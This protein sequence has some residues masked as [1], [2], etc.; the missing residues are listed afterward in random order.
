MQFSVLELDSPKWDSA[1]A[2]LPVHLRDI[3][4]LPQYAR[5]YANTYQ[6]TPFLAMLQSP[7]GFVIQPFIRR[8]LNQLPFL[9]SREPTQTFFDIANAYG[10]GGPVCSVSEPDVAA[11]LL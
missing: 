3:H 5:I 2:A 7:D 6:H 4:F 1:V 9:E 11:D 10:Y 8:A